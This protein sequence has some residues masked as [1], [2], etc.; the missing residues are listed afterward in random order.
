MLMVKLRKLK[1]M[2]KNVINDLL[3]YNLK[4][5]Q[6]NNFFKFSLDSVLLAEFVKI[7]YKDKQLLDLCSGNAPVPLIL[8]SKAKEIVAV[9]LQKPV[10]LLAKESVTLN[11]INNIQLINDN[12]KNLKN[13]FPG[14]N[15]DIITC[16][17]PYFKYNNDSIINE[18]EIK[19]IARHEITIKL[20]EIVEIAYNNLRNHGKFYLVHRAE[21]LVEIINILNKFNFGLKRM[22]MV[23]A[24]EEQ[25]CSM[26]LFEAK[27]N[28]KNNVNILKPLIHH[29]Q[30]R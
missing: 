10:Y 11:K 22:Q 16:N 3:D 28:S 17:P 8:S 1:L 27:K 2:V 15:F 21:R 23:Y 13:Y 7:D 20:E 5:V 26:V 18:S 12:I 6:N 9:E 29:V 25:N 30:G 24:G 4:I 19:A 14:N